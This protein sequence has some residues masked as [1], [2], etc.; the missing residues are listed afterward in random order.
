MALAVTPKFSTA[1]LDEVWPK[2]LTLNTPQRGVGV[3][4]TISETDFKGRSTN[5]IVRPRAIFADADSK[6]QAEQCR[7]C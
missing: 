1:A 2:V 6:E 4:V 3:F 7:V 5:N